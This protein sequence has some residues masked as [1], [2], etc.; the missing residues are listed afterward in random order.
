MIDPVTLAV[1]RGALEE[2]VY[3]MDENVVASAF[4]PIISE[5][6]DR[7]HGLFEANGDLV[8][9][10]ESSLPLFV[11]SLQAS[12]RKVVTQPPLEPGDVIVHNHPEVG[13]THVQ[14]VKL[15]TPVH[16]G[17]E[18]VFYLGSAAHW[19]D[20]GG[21]VG[22]GW[23]PHSTTV[24]AEGLVVDGVRIVRRGVLNEDV[25]SILRSNARMPDPLEGDLSAQLSALRLGAQRIEEIVARHG[26][27]AVLEVIAELQ[28]RSE[29]EAR[30]RFRELAGRRARAEDM[31]DNDGIVD[32]PI[33]IVCDLEFTGDG[34][35]L[36]LTASSDEV[37]GPVNLTRPGTVSSCQI[38]VKHWWP[39]IP[40]NAGCFRALTVKTRPGS[41]LAARFP[42]AVSGYSDVM[43]RVI[44]VTLAA[45]GQ[46]QPERSIASA[47]GTT[48]GISITWRTETGV[49]LAAWYL[50]GGYGATADVDGLVGGSPLH[51]TSDL[52]PVEVFEHRAPVRFIERSLRP[53]SGG[54]GKMRGGCGSVHEFE[55]TT[56]GAVAFLGDRT[57]KGPS[58][59]AGGGEG[60]RARWSFTIGG[61][62]R[63]VP[64]GGRGVVNFEP[65]DRMR[66]ETPGG[67][68][69]GD[70]ADRSPEAVGAD[71]R[72]G[73]VD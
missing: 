40:I 41:V 48:G 73:Y 63:E 6:K 45:L 49:S 55:F 67:G 43:Q 18:L 72:N 57:R 51:S 27:E 3:E 14:D 4:S 58:G 33:R 46:V 71:R 53:G 1:V 10:G 8:V 35:V 69:W 64:L 23:H 21:A 12:M 39:E 50:D 20:V 31:L 68:G 9:Q 11:G 15:I 54:N 2:C 37:Q 19:M 42:C 25:L 66:I 26:L 24:Y 36:D 28:T 16:I 56:S 13:G 62:H 7:A 47:F 70:P 65:G 44:D 38:A 59:I 29:E 17:G 32:Q 30:A 5:G 60:A 52:P 34:L 22:G 61:E